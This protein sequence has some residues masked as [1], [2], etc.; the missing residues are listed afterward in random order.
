M[1]TYHQKN[2]VAEQRPV[3]SYQTLNH[4][5]NSQDG[6]GS[7]G[8][9][10]FRGIV[11]PISWDKNDRP[12]Q[13]SL[14]ECDGNEYPLKALLDGHLLQTFINKEV[15]VLGSTMED[16]EGNEIL[17]YTSITPIAPQKKT[18]PQRNNG[19]YLEEYACLL[20]RSTG[21]SFFYSA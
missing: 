18:L 3:S 13:F 19:D 5:L 6:Q 9:I 1:S 11:T 20:P 14:Y 17:Y 7:T 16:S 21:P 10:Y 15:I 4:F 8:K 2:Q 12:I